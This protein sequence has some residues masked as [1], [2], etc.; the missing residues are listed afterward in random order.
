MFQPVDIVV[1]IDEVGFGDDPAV[2]RQAG[3]DPA[4][5]ELLKRAAQPHHALVA[6]R[7]MDHQLGDQAVIVGGNAIAV[8]QRAVDPNA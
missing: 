1:A 8:V 5:H 7:T 2:E 3:V 4:D 6:R